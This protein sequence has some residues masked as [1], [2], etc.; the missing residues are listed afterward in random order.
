MNARYDTPMQV[1]SWSSVRS[2]NRPSLSGASWTLFA[3]AALL[4]ILGRSDGSTTWLWSFPAA[5]AGIVAGGVSRTWV[6]IAANVVVAAVLPI[7]LFI[8]V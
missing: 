5:V 3:I 8:F 4:V 1:R 7:A 6:P 2:P